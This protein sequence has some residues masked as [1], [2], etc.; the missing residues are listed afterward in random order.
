M[1]VF[2][3]FMDTARVKNKVSTNQFVRVS[4]GRLID[5]FLTRIINI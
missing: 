4:P 2:K 3:L 1:Y 5:I